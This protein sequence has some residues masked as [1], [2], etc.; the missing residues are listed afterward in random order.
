M[1]VESEL[2]NRRHSELRVEC[3]QQ[4]LWCKLSRQCKTSSYNI[5][6]PPLSHHL[7]FILSAGMI[8]PI[9]IA[10]AASGLATAC[11]KLFTLIN[12]LFLVDESVRV[13]II[14]IE[15]LSTV[16]IAIGNTFNDPAQAGDALSSQTAQRHWQNVQRMLENCRETLREFQW[17]VDNISRSDSRTLRRPAKLIS[18][19]SRSPQLALI[20]QKLAAYRE[21]LNMSLQMVT[22]Y[23]S[24]QSSLPLSPLPPST[25]K[26]KK[27]HHKIIYI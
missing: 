26:K 18:L 12:N 1:R 8:D 6:V 19:A 14:E 25:K 5:V 22:L 15:S 24:K 20:Q 7:P 16:L 11:G 17:I 2:E 21:M 4:F 10:T 23:V 13:L 3:L 27:S 9:T